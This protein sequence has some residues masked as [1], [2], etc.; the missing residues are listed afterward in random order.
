MSKIELI[1]KLTLELS[2]AGSPT[3]EID[4][5]VI[6]CYSL[7]KSFENI[8]ANGDEPIT[9]A[10]YAKIR[11]LVR[12]RKKGEP[13][14]YIV[15]NKEFYGTNFK[16]NKHVL[17]PRPETEIL[18]EKGMEFIKSKVRKVHQVK[19]GRQSQQTTDDLPLTVLDLG[20]GSGCIIISLAKNIPPSIIHNSSFSIQFYASDISPK[21]LSVAKFNAKKHGVY[22][23][24]RFF[25][26]DL[27]D[28]SKMPKSFDL[29]IANLPYLKP[30]SKNNN[31]KSAHTLGL[32]WEPDIALYAPEKGL[33][34]IKRL[35]GYLPSKLTKTGIALLES[36][37]SQQKIISDLCAKQNLQF[38][39]ISSPSGWNGF[40]RINRK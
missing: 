17:I 13:I 29:I 10:Q 20:T 8:I 38:S 25:K 24:I 5:R 19:D 36:D 30:T 21:A 16:V 12:R 37:D 23:N 6:V 28:N 35:I 4:A 11:R 27:F 9:N 26:S 3:A 31:Y 15:K 39:R 32:N 40:S 14:A 1:N 2:L 7:S 33:K 22:D 18:V 34:I